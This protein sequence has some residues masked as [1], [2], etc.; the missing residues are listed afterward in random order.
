MGEIGLEIYDPEDKLSSC[1]LSTTFIMY[2]LLNLDM[3]YDPSYYNPT[4]FHMQ[5]SH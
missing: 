3:L 1:H 5:E 2:F 4:S